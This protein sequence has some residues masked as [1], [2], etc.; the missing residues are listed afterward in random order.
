[1]TDST[2]HFSPIFAGSDVHAGVVS[3]VHKGKESVELFLLHCSHK[4]TAAPRR[5]LF[6]SV[7]LTEIKAG[8]GGRN[9]EYAYL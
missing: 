5:A 7:V 6:A 1:M 4:I 9:S 3:K 2:F 8:I